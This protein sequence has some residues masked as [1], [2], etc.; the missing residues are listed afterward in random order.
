MDDFEIEVVSGD[1]NAMFSP[2]PVREEE[3][4]SVFHSKRDEFLTKDLMKIDLN[5]V[6]KELDKRVTIQHVDR[7]A[8]R[9]CFSAFA[10]KVIIKGEN[11]TSVLID[12]RDEIRR[13]KLKNAGR[14]NAPQIQHAPNDTSIGYAFSDDN[15]DFDD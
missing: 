5:E 6:D 2:L 3:E 9:E 1:E 12:N 10:K 11:G 7:T 14:L 8:N 15:I 13:Q 4:E